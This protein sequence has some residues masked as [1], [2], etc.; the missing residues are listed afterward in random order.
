MKSSIGIIGGGFSGC[1]LA[2]HLLEN[3]KDLQVVIFNKTSRIGPGLAYEPQSSTMLLNVKAGKM[4]AFTAIP[5]D[6]VDWLTKE[7]IF[8]LNTREEITDS[9][10]SRELYG[11]YLDQIWQNILQMKKKLDYLPRMETIL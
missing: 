10:V 8:P 11:Y 7:N 4:S 2:Y 1:M 3:T 6:F 5:T 9:F